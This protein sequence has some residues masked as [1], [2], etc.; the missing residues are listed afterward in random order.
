MSIVI[1]KKGTK[2]RTKYRVECPE[3][4]CI[5]EYN[6]EDMIIDDLSEVIVRHYTNCPQC[7]NRVSHDDNVDFSKLRIRS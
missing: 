3:C 4:G 6:K 2:E 5:Y 7:Y 1:I